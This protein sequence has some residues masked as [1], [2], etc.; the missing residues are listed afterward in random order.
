MSALDCLLGP[1]LNDLD[2]A[3]ATVLVRTLLLPDD[4]QVH[5]QEQFQ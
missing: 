1:P 2:A 5:L 4:V 3:T